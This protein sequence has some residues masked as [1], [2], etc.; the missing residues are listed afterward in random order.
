MEAVGFAASILKAP[1]YDCILEKGISGSRNCRTTRVKV[2]EKKQSESEQRSFR[3]SLSSNNYG[4]SFLTYCPPSSANV[5]F[6]HEVRLKFFRSTHSYPGF[7]KFFYSNPSVRSSLD[8]LIFLV[9]PS[10]L[11]SDRAL[12]EV[13]QRFFLVL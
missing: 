1:T 12:I 13:F 8:T 3:L 7:I 9:S 10:N 11:H 6:L 4:H 5:S 2:V